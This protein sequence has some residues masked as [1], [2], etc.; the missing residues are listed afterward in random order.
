[1]GK[2]ERKPNDDKNQMEMPEENSSPM[3][4]MDVAIVWDVRNQNKDRNRYAVTSCPGGVTWARP[5][6]SSGRILATA[7]KGKSLIRITRNKDTKQHF[8]YSQ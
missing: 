7:R 1:M 5:Q 8:K 6:A 2:S 4:K 3:M